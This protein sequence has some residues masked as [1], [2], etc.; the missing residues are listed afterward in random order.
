MDIGAAAQ[1][2]NLMT[3]VNSYHLTKSLQTSLDN[4]LQDVLT[5]IQTGQTATAC[6]ELTDFIGHVQSQ[7]GKGLTVSQATQLIAA[8]TNI[9]KVLGC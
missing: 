8:A 3:T 7:S 5:A 9:K 1:I 6:S 2:T 4:K